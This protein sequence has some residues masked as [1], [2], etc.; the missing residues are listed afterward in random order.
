MITTDFAALVS[1]HRNY[2]RTGATRSI[3][4]RA[5]QLSPQSIQPQI[6][7]RGSSGINRLNRFRAHELPTPED[8]EAQGEE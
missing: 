7:C 6:C 2:F 3:E 5:R 4:W 1:R 8:R